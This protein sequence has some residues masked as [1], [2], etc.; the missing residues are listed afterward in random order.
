ME[1]GHSSIVVVDV[2]QRGR[3]PPKR[4]C[5]KGE[6]P[7]IEDRKR[8]PHLK[9]T[10]LP[11]L[12]TRHTFGAAHTYLYPPPLLSFSPHPSLLSTLAAS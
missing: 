3:W 8:S 1:R 2:L 11:M 7:G 5:D 6:A 4:A 12:H 10:P 9:P